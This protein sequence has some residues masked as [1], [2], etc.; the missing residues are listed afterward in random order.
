MSYLSND[1]GEN[2]RAQR[3]TMAE[4]FKAYQEVVKK[5]DKN[6]KY[7]D[8]RELWL[9]YEKE[10]PELAAYAKSLLTVPASTAAVERIFSVGGAIL[11][12]SR[13]RL[14]DKVFEML[15][16]LKCNMHITRNISF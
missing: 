13:R 16:F 7:K 11:K 3:N 6:D 4:Q 8:T 10:W 15:M 9:K 14:S 5:L 12:P 2:L 1:N